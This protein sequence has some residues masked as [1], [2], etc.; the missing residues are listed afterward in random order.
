VLMLWQV[1]TSKSRKNF[2]SIF[3][4]N[5]VS[6]AYEK[7]LTDSIPQ[8]GKCSKG[9]LPVRNADSIGGNCYL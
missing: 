1:C 9:L 8:N 5:P 6:A 3:G 4:N 2:L 7:I